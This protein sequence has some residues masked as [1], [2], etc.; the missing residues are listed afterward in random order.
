[1]NKYNAHAQK[2]RLSIR[3]AMISLLEKKPFSKITVNDI[4][5]RAEIQRATFYRYFHDKYEVAEDINHFLAQCIAPNFFSRFYRHEPHDIQHLLVF[6]N[7]YGTLVNR[8]LFL[9]I[10]NVNLFQELQDSFINE[11]RTAYPDASDYE[12]YLAA[13]NF[14]STFIYQAKHASSIQEIKQAAE[15]DS[16]IRWLSKYYHI[17][18]SE[19]KSFVERTVTK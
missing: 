14:L 1:M 5:A 2:M 7:Q 13:H 17:P 12:A 4:L 6:W 19:F 11:Y 18:V 15:S 3:N 10:E 16:Q 9:Q 8:M